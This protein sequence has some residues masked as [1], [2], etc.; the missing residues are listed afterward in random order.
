MDSAE[1]IRRAVAQV[2][3]LRATTA[4]TEAAAVKRLQSRRFAATYADLLAAG[5]PAG[6]AARFFL[7]QLYGD[8]D[9]SDRDAQFARIAGTLQTVFPAAVTGTAV[10]LA[11]LHALT[12]GLDLELARALPSQPHATEAGR[13]VMAWRSVGRQPDRRRQLA[14][15]LAIGRDL[16]RLTRTPGLGVMLRMMRGPA[17][18]AG[19]GSL[20]QFLESGFE[21][22]GRLARAH[23]V[24]PFLRTIDVRE[25]ALMDLLFDGEI[26]ACE[27]TL[28]HLLGQAP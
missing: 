22:F 20:Q 9:Y 23:G 3:Q 15:V 6:G 21:T 16:G 2:Q 5:G 12:E 27:T 26:V 24:E 8:R 19:M 25:K 11:E 13:Y 4:A 10:A 17:A 28:R 14:E 7:D 1:R 18:A